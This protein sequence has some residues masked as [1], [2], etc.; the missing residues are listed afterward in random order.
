MSEPTWSQAS[1]LFAAGNLQASMEIVSK[2]LE[3]TPSDPGLL[4]LCGRILAS[5][6]NQTDAITALALCV[7]EDPSNYQARWELA[8]AHKRLASH[9][10]YAQAR[11]I[12]LDLNRLYPG[13]VAILREAAGC[14]ARIGP[15]ELAAE[16]WHQVI[17]QQPDAEAYYELS[18]IYG[19]TDRLAE[20]EENLRLAIGLDPERY[21]KSAEDLKV[22]ESSRRVAK[23]AA[24]VKKGRYPETEMIQ[25]D[26][27]KVILD[28]V[29]ADIK[30][31]PGFIS[32]ETTF[33]TMG[34]CFAR[35]VVRALQKG[36]Y[37]ASTMDVSEYI[38]TTYAN[39]FFVDWL[40]GTLPAG[41]LSER[42][43]EIVPAG[44]S[45]EM[46]IDR[47]KSCDVY[48]ITLGVA[49]A[50]FNRDNGEFVMPRPTA[51]NFRA[52]AEKYLFR[53]TS[54]AENVDNVLYLLNYVRSLNPG[55][56]IIVT[57]SPVPLHM[58][59][60][61]RSAVAAD[62]LSKSTLRVAAH[63]IVHNSGL[64]G[65]YYWPSFEIF[66]WMGSHLAEAVYGTDDGAAWHVSEALV[67]LTVSCFVEAFGTKSEN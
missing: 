2:E 63:E 39:R 56:K 60:E 19:H 61:F 29:A 24:T 15:M 42:I 26:L 67:D 10:D 50:F 59:F 47:I 34:S 48:I 18:E 51:L 16:L 52:L 8:L 4:L 55:V 66:R 54:V 3:K 65:I 58:T 37:R 49:P 28:Y 36:G 46:V 64:E 35:N 9:R 40:D 32:K 53:T 17:A 13:Q 41:P 21:G 31:A 11:D 57:E 1:E 25:N 38:N 62:C 6:G 23:A 30:D 20:A 12:L 5:S 45:K 22:V 14:C 27:R 33:F 44:F 43:L 7:K